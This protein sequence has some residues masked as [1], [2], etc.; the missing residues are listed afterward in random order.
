MIS[1]WFDNL[2][3]GK[4]LRLSDKIMDSLEYF[5]L[6]EFACLMETDLIL[7]IMMINR[8]GEIDKTKTMVWH[9]IVM[10]EFG[11]GK[12]FGLEAKSIQG[13]KRA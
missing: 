3:T 7:T 13:K 1:D 9:V 10:Y 2:G 11:I 12:V 4:L 8:Y 5:G 6:F